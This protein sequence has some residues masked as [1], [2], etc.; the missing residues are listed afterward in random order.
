MAIK[1]FKFK[2]GLKMNRPK[3]ITNEHLDYLDALRDSGITNMFG[4]SPY[5]VDEFKVSTKEAREILTYWMK[6]FSKRLKEK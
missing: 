1:F 6:T 4:A 3:F 5:I 2:R